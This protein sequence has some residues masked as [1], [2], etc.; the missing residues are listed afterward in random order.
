MP[1]RLSDRV[2]VGV[3]YVAGAILIVAVAVIMLW[4]IVQG[5]G[6]ISWDFLTGEPAPGSLEQGVS[7]GILPAI[8]GTFLVVAFGMAVAI[9]LG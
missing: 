1:V 5:L 2:G 9:P 4:L 6:T 3:A 8:V 7:G